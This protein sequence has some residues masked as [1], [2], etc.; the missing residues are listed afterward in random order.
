MDAFRHD[1]RSGVRALIRRPAFSALAILT[2]AAG[3]GLNA[4]VFTAAN[5]LFLKGAAGA[6]LPD[7]GWIF[8]TTRG[9]GTGAL[10]IRDVEAIERATRTFA[11]VAAEGR[12]PL[13]LAW[14]GQ[15]D[16]IWALL[17]TRR[18]FDVI[19]ERPLAGRTFGTS[20]ADGRAVLVAERFWRDRFG[21]A[22]LSGQT[23]TLNGVDVAIVGVIADDHKGP[24][25]LFTPDVWVPLD[26]RHAMQ[27]PRSLDAADHRW[28]T[29]FGRLASNAAPAA[30]RGELDAILAAQPGAAVDEGGAFV[31]FRDR[32]PDARALQWAG[33]VALTTVGLVL[34]IACFNVAGLLMARALERTREMAVRRALGAGPWR[35][36]RMLLAESLV[37]SAAAGL[38]AVILAYWSGSLLG[39]F[40]LPSPIPQ[41]LDLRP[42]VALLL[43]VTALVAVAGV[44]PALAPVLQAM[45]VDVT[46]ALKADSAGG[47]RPARARSLFVTLQVAG[48]TL[49][50]VLAVLFGATF[51]SALRVDIG[52]EADRALTAQ[53]QPALQGFSADEGR[54]FVDAYVERLRH[55]PGILSAGAGD[56][57]S[58]YVGRPDVTR[59][60]T[61]TSSCAADDCTPADTYHVG[62]GYFDALG[63]P[64]VAGRALLKDDVVTGRGVVVSARLADTLWPGA[65]AVGQPLRLAR[66][67]RIVEVVGVA[68]DI[69]HRSMHE[70]PARALYLPITSEAYA[71]AVTV[72]ART[73]GDPAS[74]M[75]IA[76][77]GWTAL[78]SRLPVPVVETM[79]DRLRMPLWPARVAAWFF[80]VCSGLAVLLATVGL[81]AAIVYAAAQRT[82]EFGIRAAI[83]ASASRIG[84]LVFRD[85]LAL[86][87]PG[88]VM[89][90]VAAW[91]LAR[92][93]GARLS[94]IDTGAPA[95]YAAVAAVQLT[96]ALAAC[97]LPARRAARVDPIRALRVD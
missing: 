13:A 36:A 46:R 77:T 47:G 93:S 18:Y 56:R 80:G 29:A 33:L 49:F 97:L 74:L 70:S 8:R 35:L 67:N 21:D 37:L 61:V 95:V 64:I 27:L 43:F 45:R 84:R 57:M 22:P 62:D 25:G 28:L 39:A 76:R 12:M 92:L 19:D 79:A 63:I 72:V 14:K 1:L 66:E 5:A 9:A 10:S 71:G 51:L 78:D 73:A 48:A 26:A 88:V 17:V 68:G 55:T 65:S 42:D 6:H 24:G 40:A 31:L 7:A 91:T 23:L 54:A 60:S 96:V 32:H 15:T 53:V 38:A 75:G 85:G 52:F 20:D 59:V 4:V 41:R 94:G 58:F 11:S 87:L 82:R 16:R 30:A 83:G 90:C 50:L 69:I 81:F 2:L 44:L 34:L 89:G 3:I 86:A